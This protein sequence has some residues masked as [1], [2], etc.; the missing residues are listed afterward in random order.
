MPHHYPNLFFPTLL[1]RYETTLPYNQFQ[2]F[3]G[4]SVTEE[5]ARQTEEETRPQSNN[6][7]WYQ[8][9]KSRVT[10]SKFKR[11]CGRQRDFE[12]L[13][14]QLV[15]KTVQTHA[16][17]AG[18]DKEPAAATMYAEAYGRN[19]Y[20]VGF[21]INPTAFYLGASP[22]RRVYDPDETSQVF[23]LLEIKCPSV[24][25]KVSQSANT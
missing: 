25:W 19:V 18:I 15:S 13:P 4:L 12:S 7:L 6:T 3:W 22:D 23:G 9:R 16:M 21:I 1:Q 17:K 14:K 2:I 11:V 20:K 5:Q 24:E 8:L 10:A